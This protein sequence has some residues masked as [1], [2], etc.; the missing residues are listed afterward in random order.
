MDTGTEKYK[1]P[2][3]YSLM[4]ETVSAQSM[5]SDLSIEGLY[6]IDTISFTETQEGTLYSIVF[7]DEMNDLVNRLISG[8]ETGEIGSISM[9]DMRYDV[10]IGDDGIPVSI[11]MTFS[12]SMDMTI[13]GET[14]SYNFKYDMDCAINSIGDDVVINFP[15]FSGYSELSAA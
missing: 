5:Y 8:L 12:V 13:E 14:V 2:L 7:S 11:N 10:L 1:T 6:M 4:L 15:D 9:N 3:D